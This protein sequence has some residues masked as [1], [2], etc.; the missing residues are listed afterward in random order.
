[1]IR[2]V[3]P[4]YAKK[5]LRTFG[6]KVFDMIEASPDRLREVN[7]IGP[8]RPAASPPPGPAEG[9]AGNHGVPA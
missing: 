9:G 6:E 7:G 4:A 3:G 5:L 1:M 2:G 8:V